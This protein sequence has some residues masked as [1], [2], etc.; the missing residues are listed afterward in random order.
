MGLLELMF[1][2]IMLTIIAVGGVSLTIGE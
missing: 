1:G 2:A